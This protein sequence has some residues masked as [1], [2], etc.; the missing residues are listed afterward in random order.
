MLSMN[1][2]KSYLYLVSKDQKFDKF[3]ASFRCLRNFYRILQLL[4]P[5][6]GTFPCTKDARSNSTESISYLES[7]RMEN[8]RKQ[9]NRTTHLSLAQ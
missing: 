4:L 5:I 1:E 8:D 6:I 9:E 7:S 2:L 3:A